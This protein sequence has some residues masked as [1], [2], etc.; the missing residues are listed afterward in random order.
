MHSHNRCPHG[1]R[2]DRR[3]PAARF[4]RQDNLIDAGEDISS[5][6]EMKTN[7]KFLLFLDPSTLIK[8]F[9]KNTLKFF[10]GSIWSQAYSNIPDIPDTIMDQVRGQ[11]KQIYL[12]C[13]E[14]CISFLAAQRPSKIQVKRTR[15]SLDYL[16]NKFEY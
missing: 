1:K 10:D 7:G 8:I 3:P 16:Q 6:G 12:N 4:D 13:L 14:D 2:P 5:L 15:S 11:T 9:Q